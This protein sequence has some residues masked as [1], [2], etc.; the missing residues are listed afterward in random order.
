MNEHPNELELDSY[1][2]QRNDKFIKEHP[3]KFI[4]N[5]ASA[6]RFLPRFW[7]TSHSSLFGIDK[8]NTEYLIEKNYKALAIKALLLIMHVIVL[9]LGVYGTYLARDKWRCTIFLTGAILYFCLH[10]NNVPRYH[11]PV[12]PLIIIFMAVAVKAVLRQFRIFNLE[13]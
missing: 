3:I 7:I 12:L 2:K 1:L 13:F 6:A 5:V 8:P 10:L 4:L 11:V 9:S